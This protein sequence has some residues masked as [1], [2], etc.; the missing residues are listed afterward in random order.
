MFE[1]NILLISLLSIY[2]SISFSYAFSF[3]LIECLIISFFILLFSF[4]LTEY[5]ANKRGIF[6]K[7]NFWSFGI[8]ISFIFSLFKIPIFPFLSVEEIY[9][10]KFKRIKKPK[11]DE[12]RSYFVMFGFFMF[13]F[14][15]FGIIINPKISLFS[16]IFLFSFLLPY[17][18][19][20]GSQIFFFNPL[21]YGIFFI[22][23][24]IL[25][26]TSLMLL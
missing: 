24:I 1:K 19:S 14:S 16:S 20:I 10:K 22:F 5:I 17:K 12:V 11:V 13:L 25:S 18:N 3:N 9:Y 26:I 2:S 6:F 8:L 7:I 21:I 15:L 23:S 4:L